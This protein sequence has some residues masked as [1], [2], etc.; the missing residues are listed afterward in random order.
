MIFR[1]VNSRIDMGF[2]GY[3]PFIKGKTLMEHEQNTIQRYRA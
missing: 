1:I 2:N 3:G